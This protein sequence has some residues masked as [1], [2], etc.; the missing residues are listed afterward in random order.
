MCRK[1]LVRWRSVNIAARQRLSAE[2]VRGRRSRPKELSAQIFKQSAYL[3]RGERSGKCCA[4]SASALW[5]RPKNNSLILLKLKI[6]ASTVIFYLTALCAAYPHTVRHAI[7]LGAF[8]YGKG[9]YNAALAFLKSKRSTGITL[10]WGISGAV[11]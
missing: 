4:L 3:K 10:A 1:G 11:L 7:L 6:A 2:T 9:N 8:G 5:S